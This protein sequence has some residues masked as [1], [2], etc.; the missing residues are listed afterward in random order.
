MLKLSRV[1]TP[2]LSQRIQQQ[3]ID[4]PQNVNDFL[5]RYLFSWQ[6]VRSGNYPRLYCLVMLSYLNPMIALL[7]IWCSFSQSPTVSCLPSSH[8]AIQALDE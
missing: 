8:T 4:E 3:H 7:L 1:E 6:L 5:A 2:F